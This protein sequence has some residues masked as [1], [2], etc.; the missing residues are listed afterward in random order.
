MSSMATLAQAQRGNGTIGPRLE[1]IANFLPILSTH[2][3][4]ELFTRAGVVNCSCQG[5]VTVPYC[6]AA[7]SVNSMVKARPIVEER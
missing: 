2:V 4:L 3:H 5:P 1:Q 7:S 6:A